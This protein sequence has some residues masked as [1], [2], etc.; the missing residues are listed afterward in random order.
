MAHLMMKLEENVFQYVSTSLDMTLD[1][2]AP[3]LIYLKL[4]I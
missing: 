4:P 1:R 2:I 3:V